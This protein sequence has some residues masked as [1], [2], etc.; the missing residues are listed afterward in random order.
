MK[1]IILIL[2]ILIL[3]SNNTFSQVK[4]YEIPDYKLIKK[5]IEDKSSN[6][7]YPKLLERM[8]SND[9]LLNNED[10]RH[11]YFGYVFNQKYSSYFRSP[12]EEKLKKYYQS[13][14]INEKDY[15]EI[16][17]LAEHSISLFPFDLRQMNFLAY[18]YHLKGDEISAKNISNRFHKIIEAII[19]SG[20][21]EKCETG[22]HVISVSHEYVLLNLFELQNNSQS[23]VGNCDYMAFEKG[24]YKIDGMY[25][26][27]EK[28]LENEMKLFDR[29]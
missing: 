27:I 2:T 19:S 18:I 29:K 26:S 28:I 15:N 5:N 22:F 25:F 6:Y 8:T 20:N 4:K 11:L 14:K 17:K 23:L 13:D 21:G 16:I 9:S 7:Y 24:K 10:Y 3:L 12:D 1:K